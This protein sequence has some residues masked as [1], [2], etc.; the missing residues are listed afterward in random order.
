MKKTKL[1]PQRSPEPVG[2]QD[3]QRYR[4]AADEP[5]SHK[6]IQKRFLRRLLIDNGLR[7]F[8]MN[9]Y[10]QTSISD[11]VAPVGMSVRSFFRYFGSKEELLFSDNYA[12][13]RA[14][15]IELEHRPRTEPVLQ[16][17]RSVFLLLAQRCDEERETTLRR[18]KIIYSSPALRAAQFHDLLRWEDEYVEVIRRTRKVPA[19]ELFRVRLKVSVAATTLIAAFDA[20]QADPK[21]RTMVYWFNEAFSSIADDSD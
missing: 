20:W 12:G 11:I 6:E 5:L 2:S 13:G 1:R 7:L 17:M 16:A 4:L 19:S 9:G 14:A 15:T 3:P 10:D 21:E 8:A 18:V